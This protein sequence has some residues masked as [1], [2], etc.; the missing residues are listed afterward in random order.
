MSNEHSLV[1]NG[2]L[3]LE[4]VLFA[5]YRLLV[6]ALDGDELAAVLAVLRENHLGER[7][8]AQ[9]KCTQLDN[10]LSLILFTI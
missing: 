7:A 3:V 1:E 10:S 6:D 2:D 8:A 5:A 4:R 9:H